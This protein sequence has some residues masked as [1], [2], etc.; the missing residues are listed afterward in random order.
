MT[1]PATMAA[2]ILL[3]SKGPY[4]QL[5]NSISR[6]LT[7]SM[8]KPSV[9]NIA[10]SDKN[11]TNGLINILTRARN[12][13]DKTTVRNFWLPKLIL[14]APRIAAV[15]HKP[16]LEPIQRAANLVNHFSIFNNYSGFS[17]L[18]PDTPPL[19]RL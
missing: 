15:S 4:S 2:H 18:K 1:T 7:T 11:T 12:K 8:N 14:S 10:G 19:Q 3:T 6:P 16:K 9:I 5:T 13:P 17:G